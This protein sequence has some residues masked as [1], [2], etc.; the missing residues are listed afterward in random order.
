MNSGFKKIVKYMSKQAYI[1]D[2]KQKNQTN[3]WYPQKLY[4]QE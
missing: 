2:I 1:I 3:K 4:L